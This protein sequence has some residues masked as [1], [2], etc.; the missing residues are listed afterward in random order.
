LRILKGWKE[1]FREEEEDFP[2]S[3]DVSIARLWTLEA[4]PEQTCWRIEG[5]VSIWALPMPAS[6]LTGRSNPII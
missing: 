3:L 2:A 6:A 1:N 4:I 5:Q